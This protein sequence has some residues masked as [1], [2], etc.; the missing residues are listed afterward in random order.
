[1]LNISDRVR[2]DDPAA[3]GFLFELLHGDEAIGS[4]SCVLMGEKIIKK[5]AVLQP[6]SGGIFPSGVSFSTAPHLSFVEPDVLELLPD[7][8]YPVVANTLL[9]TLFRRS[10]LATLARPTGPVP[11]TALDIRIGLD[12]MDAGYGNWCTTR[13]AAALCGPHH[14]RDSIDPFGGAYAQP[15]RWAD[16]LGRVSLVRELF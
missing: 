12:L 16:L 13:V 14:R 7:L 10:A 4:A 9:L 15:Q 5:E 2:L 3:L 11:A 8:T 6:A 1:M